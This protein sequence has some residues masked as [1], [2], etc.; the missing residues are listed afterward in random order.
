VPDTRDTPDEPDAPMRREA[1][2]SADDARPPTRAERRAASAKPRM[3]MPAV[4]WDRFARRY[5][6]AL[7]LC[8]IVIVGG[9]VGV[10][11]GV[12]QKLSRIGHVHNLELAKEPAANAGNFL[13]IGSDARTL[14]QTA[15]QN[16]AFGS[17][18]QEGGQ[19]SDTMMIVHVDPSQKRM[20]VV[21][22]PRD[23][24]VNIPGKGRQKINAAFNGGPQLLIDTIQSDFG[25]KISHYVEVGFDSFA[26][27]V[28]AIGSVPV[29]FPA[30]AYDLCTGLYEPSAG[31]FKLNGQQALQYVRARHLLF[32]RDGRWRDASPRGDLDRV[33]R[34]QDFIRQL[35]TLAFKKSESDVFAANDIANSVVGKLKVDDALANKHSELLA[36][37]RAFR[38]VDPSDP[39]GLQTMTLP[40]Q[41]AGDNVNLVLKQPDADDLFQRLNTF[42][43][44]PA[45]P[46]NI[47]PDQIKVH[48]LNGTGVANQAN[49]VLQTLVTQ[50]HFVSAGAGDASAPAAI[51]EVHY[52][53]QQLDAA[54]AVQ[55]YL[56]G[57]GRLVDDPNLPDNAVVILLGADFKQV[58]SPVILYVAEAQAAQQAA[59]SSSS[60]T[61][62]TTGVV[63][64]KPP[65][66]SCP[67]T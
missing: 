33:A 16:Q 54:R 45:P 2:E 36:L 20:L 64:P 56:G 6:I 10:R 32:Y 61:T 13:V 25:I 34:Q 24:L 9:L 50:Y 8:C 1:S 37:V 17:A 40:V 44:T 39:N 41:G 48:V 43:G 19:R 28:D 60:T 35:A 59:T 53:P 30:P 62:T 5:L 14:D 47:P 55:T 3:K 52:R 42:G 29:S 57:A 31:T 26:G 4:A 12:N 15:Q 58:V 66:E 63:A 22:L 7:G 67:Q 65:R 21:S 46:K 11:A 38:D 23:T 51:T 49:S 27:I 18:Q